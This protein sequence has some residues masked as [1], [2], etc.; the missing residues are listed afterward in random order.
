MTSEDDRYGPPTHTCKYCSRCFPA[1]WEKRLRD[2]VLSVDLLSNEAEAELAGREGCEFFHCVIETIS[3]RDEKYEGQVKIMIKRESGCSS[4]AN[5]S[6]YLTGGAII[7]RQIDPDIRGAARFSF[8]PT[9]KST[10]TNPWFQDVVTPPNLN[11]L[12]KGAIEKMRTWFDGR[13]KDRE[14]SSISKSAIKK[15]RT[16]FHGRI[17]G[18]ERSPVMSSETSERITA[19]RL[20]K[21]EPE[22]DIVCLVEMEGP[23]TY[24]VLS[25]C[26]GGDQST[27]T[28]KSNMA[29]HV[30][31]IN[32]STLSQ[33]IQDAIRVTKLLQLNYIWVDALCIVQDDPEDLGREISKQGRIYQNGAITILAGGAASTQSGFLHHR[34]RLHPRFIMKVDLPDSREVRL[35]TDFEG[36]GNRFT[37]EIPED[38]VDSRAWIYQEVLLS[39]HVLYFSPTQLTFFSP[40]AVHA[41]G[42][43]PLHILSDIR[44]SASILLL[45]PKIKSPYFGIAVH[46]WHKFLWKYS[47]LQLSQPADKLLALSA[48]AEAYGCG[49]MDS[50]TARNSYKAGLWQQH[51]PVSLAWNVN[52]IFITGRPPYRAPSWSWASVDGR[53]RGHSAYTRDPRNERYTAKVLRCEIQLASSVAPY[54]QVTGGELHIE[55]HMKDVSDWF[56][57]ND[58]ILLEDDSYFDGSTVNFSGRLDASEPELQQASGPDCGFTV[59]IFCLLASRGYGF[60]AMFVGLV[61]RKIDEETVYSRIGFVEIQIPDD[62]DLQKWVDTFERRTIFIV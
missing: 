47:T 27:K 55:A 28:T 38:P 12:S 54:G 17:R 23:E 61:L 1:M 57:E 44:G 50:H 42:G 56:I 52:P 26:W 29:L 33:S 25:Y 31:G 62:T 4:G 49:I 7:R 3:S 5:T 21:L 53:I 41:D 15:M 37:I 58:T 34:T 9:D 16:W 40:G 20:L 8:Y 45:S 30:N 43:P 2:T 24:A 6:T 39:P 60:N 46:N 48:I 22:S 32:I 14:P 19:K 11:P 18:R 35:I 59:S 13:I 51:M 10:D 36:T